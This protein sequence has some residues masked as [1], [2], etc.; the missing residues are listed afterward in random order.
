MWAELKNFQFLRI[1]V[2]VEFPADE[3][4]LIETI[5]GRRPEKVR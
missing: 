5:T 2:L 4:G 3:D 1:D